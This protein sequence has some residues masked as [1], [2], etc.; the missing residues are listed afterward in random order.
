[1]ASSGP[2]SHKQ[3][4]LQ[5]SLLD[6]TQV[7][8]HVAYLIQKNVDLVNLNR[9]IFDATEDGAY[10]KELDAAEEYDRKVS[11]VV[12]SARFFESMPATR[13]QRVLQRRRLLYPT[14]MPGGGST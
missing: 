11:Y 10:E 4:R 13:R 1:M 6:A 9:V 2:A 3:I 7:N 14:P 12:F 8:T 5:A